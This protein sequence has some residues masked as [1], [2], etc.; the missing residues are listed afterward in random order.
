M[1]PDLLILKD[2]SDVKM[3]LKDEMSRVKNVLQKLQSYKEFNFLEPLIK[4]DF[5]ARAGDIIIG[6]KL[7]DTSF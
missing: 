6:N 3:L 7:F 5:M 4:K 2:L 1:P